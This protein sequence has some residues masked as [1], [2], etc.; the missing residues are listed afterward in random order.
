MRRNWKKY[1]RELVR[2]GEILIDPEV[3]GV[4][5][6]KQKKRGRPYIYPDPLIKLLLFLKF[7]LRL[8]YR[9]TEGVARKTFGKLGIKIPN[10]RTLHY[11]LS[12]GEFC[13]KE[14]PKIEELSQ[15][16]VIVL[17]SSGLKV[18]NGGEW[19]RRRWG[20]KPRRGWVKIHIAFDIRSKQVVEL[21]VTDERISDCK[22]AIELVEGVKEKAKK[23][24][25]RV[26]KV[27]A[28]A[29]YDTH[30]FFRY[31]GK[32]KIEPAVLVRRGAKIR[33]NPYRD[34]VIRAIRRGKRKWKKLV[35][36][37]KRWL[38][39]GFFSSFKRWFGEY[40]SS[41]R[42]ENIRKELVFKV[43]IVNMFLAMS[44]G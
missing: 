17:D 2:R 3:I 15:D 25:K 41:V 23:K 20:K 1:N 31:L 14:L 37:G 12:K 26:K 9:Q 38:V 40:V 24:G 33:G 21:E 30:E 10:F 29:G 13:L 11:R 34:K 4:V 19:L 35:G 16:F 42:F 6:N 8:P 32:E 7:A 36:Y 44:L 39:E 43:A 27:I 28:D 22:K 5:Q 18:T